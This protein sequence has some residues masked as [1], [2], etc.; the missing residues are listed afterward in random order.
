M[1]K[2]NNLADYPLVVVFGDT[3][4]GSLV[5]LA[6]PHYQFR[7]KGQEV[8]I[9]AS[10]LQQWIYAQW[11]KDWN[12]VYSLITDDNDKKIRDLYLVHLGDVIEGS[13]HQDTEVF[14]N[15]T[16]EQLSVARPL[17]A[18]QWSWADYKVLIYGTT[19]HEGKNNESSQRY[20][21]MINADV[22]D[23]AYNLILPNDVIFNLSHHATSAITTLNNITKDSH[24]P[25]GLLPRYAVRGH[26]HVVDDTGEKY[27]YTRAII[28]PCWQARTGYA[29]K[30]ANDNRAD[31]GMVIYD[32]KTDQVKITRHYSKEVSSGRPKLHRLGLG[33]PIERYPEE[34]RSDRRR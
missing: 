30:V 33:K 16:E 6:P 22:N 21:D 3:H 7:R 10:V 28:A 11:V 32:S 27:S 8:H 29:W 34:I 23:Q 20:A 5:A 15:N 2:K 9:Q 24:K 17:M 4:I 13:H 25:E 19:E 1:I 26:K 12:L 14:S 18:Q 31:I